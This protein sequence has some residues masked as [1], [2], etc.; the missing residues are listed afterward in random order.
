MKLRYQIIPEK[1]V[2]AAF[3]FN[4][5]VHHNFLFENQK[6]YWFFDLSLLHSS[7]DLEVL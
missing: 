1:K 6:Y 4:H 7:D 2:S 5:A 3:L